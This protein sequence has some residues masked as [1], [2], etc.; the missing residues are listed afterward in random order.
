MTFVPR[1]FKSQSAKL[2][3]YCAVNGNASLNVTE[4][5]PEVYNKSQAREVEF[6]C[7]NEFCKQCYFK[8]FTV[9]P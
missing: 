6:R 4:K 3:Y 8:Q 7:C 1:Q 2:G 5:L 9:Y